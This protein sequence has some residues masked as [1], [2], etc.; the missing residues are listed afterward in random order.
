[1]N[2]KEIQEGTEVKTKKKKKERE[3]DKLKRI[4]IQ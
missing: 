2:N 4:K 3:R 1:M